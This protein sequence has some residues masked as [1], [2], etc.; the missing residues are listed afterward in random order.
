[1]TNEVT[2]LDAPVELAPKPKRNVNLQGKPRNKKVTFDKAIKD[3][4]STKMGQGRSKIFLETKTVEEEPVLKIDPEKW[5]VAQYTGGTNRQDGSFIQRINGETATFPLYEP[6]VC[7]YFFVLAAQQSGNVDFQNTNNP[8]AKN[9]RMVNNAPKFT[10]QDVI[11]DEYQDDVVAW[12]DEIEESEGQR[13]PFAT[14][15]I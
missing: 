12:I 10:I 3:M 15:S 7:R 13:I 8:N 9:M 5:V 6:V 14:P 2:E 4:P 1:M 11:E